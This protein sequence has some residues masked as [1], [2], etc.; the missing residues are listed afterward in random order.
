MSEKRGRKR[1]ERDWVLNYYALEAKEDSGDMDNDCDATIKP[2]VDT[3]D[4]DD[5]TYRY[6]DFC[7]PDDA[8]IVYYDQDCEG[9]TNVDI[10]SVKDQ[11]LV[12]LDQAIIYMKHHGSQDCM[13][14]IV[15]C[16]CQL[17]QYI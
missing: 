2:H 3:H 4:D 6:D 8:P 15:Y 10:C 13:V 16:L 7:V 5:N 11:Y 12:A 17:R 14:D 9:K 1:A